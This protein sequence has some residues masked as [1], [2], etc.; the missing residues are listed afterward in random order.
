M[1]PSRTSPPP[2]PVETTTRNSQVAQDGLG[3]LAAIDELLGTDPAATPEPMRPR[4]AEIAVPAAPTPKYDAPP[5]PRPKYDAPPAPTPKV[6]AARPAASVAQVAA[7]PDIG[8]EGTHFVQLAGSDDRGA[9]TYEWRRIAGRA[10][11]T[12]SGRDALLTRGA[13]FHRLLV[14]PFASRTE[15]Q[16][17]VNRLRAQG[18]DSFAWTRNPSQLRIDRL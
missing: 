2:T 7:S 18:V 12:L 11:G 14:G 1:R 5:P 8:I 4:V 10:N 16:E 15:A 17:M 6:E 9:M 13:S 3:R